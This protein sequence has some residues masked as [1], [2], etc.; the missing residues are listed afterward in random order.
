MEK[1]GK[2]AMLQWWRADDTDLTGFGLEPPTLSYDAINPYYSEFVFG[3]P[4]FQFKCSFFFS[5]PLL[6]GDRVLSNILALFFT[7]HFT[8]LLLFNQDLNK[9]KM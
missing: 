7:W 2:R 6:Y 9:L 1:R 3:I 5:F 8:V 4:Y